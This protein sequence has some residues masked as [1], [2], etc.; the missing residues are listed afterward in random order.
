MRRL[1]LMAVVVGVAAV[2][3]GPV[4]LAQ[5]PAGPRQAPNAP[6]AVA[7]AGQG[8]NQAASGTDR[9]T[10][11]QI[12]ANSLVVYFDFG[13][14]N[15][16]SADS[17]ALDQASRLYRAGHPVQM[18]VSGYTDTAGAPEYNL[19]LSEARAS[20]VLR[21]LVARGIPAERF[22]LV[23]NGATELAVPTDQGVSNAANRRVVLSWR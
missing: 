7:P 9:P 10:P 19:E 16:T 3:G 5:G 15:L 2:M 23:A 18:T 4:A 21:Q 13:G 22:H 6:D 17:A 14:T 11:G 12:S 1:S 8:G 20:E